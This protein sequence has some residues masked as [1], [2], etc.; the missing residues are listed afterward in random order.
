MRDLNFTARVFFHS[1]TET[2][3]IVLAQMGL[4][5][6]EESK[7]A[8]LSALKQK[9]QPTALETMETRLQHIAFSHVFMVLQ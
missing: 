4:S 1:L 8:L 2:V 3:V 7:C 5:S 6:A 9:A